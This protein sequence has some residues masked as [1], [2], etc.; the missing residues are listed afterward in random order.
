MEREIFKELPMYEGYEISNFGNVKSLG[1]DKARKE[2]I[3]TPARVT[4]G[5]MIVTIR[6]DK[7]QHTLYVWQSV[8]TTFWEERPWRGFV[9]W[10]KDGD[11]TNNRLD[12]LHWVT[13]SE[14]VFQNGK[15]DV[16]GR[17]RSK[18]IGLFN[19]YGELLKKYHSIWDYARDY[20]YTRYEVS[21][22]LAIVAKEWSLRV[23]NSILKYS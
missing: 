15:Y 8:L 19:E 13:H 5:Q 9:V 21:K 23:G 20:G 14:K 3:L 16:E 18:K 4:T 11:L 7:I 6:R 1:N 10:H 22:Q 12:N 17:I 2:K